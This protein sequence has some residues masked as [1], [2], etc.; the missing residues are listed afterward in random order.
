MV[1]M[2]TIL[3]L[4]SL[5]MFVG[6]TIFLLS[7]E[8]IVPPEVTASH[9][10]LQVDPLLDSRYT[11]GARK[12]NLE[13]FGLPDAMVARAIDRMRRIEDRHARKIQLLLD[14][15]PDPNA[16]AMAM[17][18]QTSQMRPRYS[19][20]RFLVVEDQG[21][22]GSIRV[23]RATGIE[24]QDW[25]QLSPISDVYARAELSDGREED[26]TLMA[27]AAIM[28]GKEADLLA[29]HTPWGSGL[30]PGSWSWDKVV[31]LHPGI[32]ERIV[33]YFAVMHLFVEEATSDG[34]I[35]GEEEG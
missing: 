16:V 19:A 2:R 12:R 4:A 20:L 11:S 5:T 15:S 7:K 32:E 9:V 33:E 17:C 23:S 13:S 29:G 18:G 34:G 24:E 26:A 10:A 21:Q 14:G 27:I 25:S 30:L 6:V 35:C 28:T 31:E 1:S 22:R 3:T 8:D